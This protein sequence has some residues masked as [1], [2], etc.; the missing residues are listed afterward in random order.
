M[1][2]HWNVKLAQ[3]NLVKIEEYL[4]TNVHAVL[5]HSYSLFFVAFIIGLVFDF[6][7]PIKIFHNPIV[8]FSG[9]AM[10]FF[11]SFLVFWAQH[12][13]SHLKKNNVTKEDFCKGPYCYT[14]HPT[15]MGLFLLILGFG[16]IA[17]A[18]FIVF[19][20]VVSFVVAR[21]VFVRKQEA[22]LV[23]KYGKPYIEYQKLVK[24]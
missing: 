9:F 18:F 8:V 13:S 20:T 16:I 19:F 6:V 3:H 24:F 12:T 10:L 2:N 21:I 23:H 11:A 14:R 7:F 4:T 22:V 15:H 1:T 17:N 5:A